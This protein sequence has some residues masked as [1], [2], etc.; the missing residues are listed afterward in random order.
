[1]K[2]GL[3]RMRSRKL[4]SI[5]LWKS[6]E[7]LNIHKQR[8]LFAINWAESLFLGSDKLSALPESLS[9]SCNELSALPESLSHLCNELSGLPESLSHLCNKLSGKLKSNWTP[10][11]INT[12]KKITKKAISIEMAFFSGCKILIFCSV[13]LVREKAIVVIFEWAANRKVRIPQ[14]FTGY[15]NEISLVI[16]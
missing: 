14:K 8:A 9:H 6:F 4:R 2:P 12:S 13:I 16:L 1:M 3:F 15:K 5:R 7:N 11:F 10:A